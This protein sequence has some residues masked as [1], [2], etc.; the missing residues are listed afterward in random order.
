MSAQENDFGL[1]RRRTPPLAV[2]VDRFKLAVCE[3]TNSDER[4]PLS[5]T[6]RFKVRTNQGRRTVVQGHEGE[7]QAYQ[8]A[9]FA[10]NAHLEH[11]RLRA[12]PRPGSLP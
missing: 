1:D 2:F 3:A 11:C 9:E 8:N 5:A 12:G 7:A 10:F 4:Y 6:E